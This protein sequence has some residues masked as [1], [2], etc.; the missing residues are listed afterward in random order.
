MHANG[1]SY[2]LD[3]AIPD[4]QIGIEW[5]G[6]AYHGTRS[7]FD[8]DSDKRADL[9][10]AGWLILDFTSRSKPQRI[11]QAVTAAIAQ[12]QHLRLA[13]ARARVG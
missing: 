9:T 2:R 3:R 13:A 8:H 5:N 11:F 1:H 6:Y 4:L 10:A 12:R 7:G